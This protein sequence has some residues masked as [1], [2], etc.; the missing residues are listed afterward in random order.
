MTRFLQYNGLDESLPAAEAMQKLIQVYKMPDSF[1]EDEIRR[2]IGVLF[3]MYIADFSY[4]NPFIVAEDVDMEI[5]S[6]LSEQ[7]AKYPGVTIELLSQRQYETSYAAH[8]L[9]R[10]GLIL[11]EDYEAFAAQ[12]YP[13]LLYTSRC[14]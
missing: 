3:D 7:Q 12:G 2:V 6:I 9:G 1:T 13:C 14:V 5:V 11:A 10:T 8:I 4:D